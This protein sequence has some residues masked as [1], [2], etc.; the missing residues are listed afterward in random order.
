MAFS[1]RRRL[2]VNL[3]FVLAKMNVVC[4]FVFAHEIFEFLGASRPTRS[5]PKI[6]SC[7]RVEL[8]RRAQKL[9]L[10]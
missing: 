9:E 7:I 5:L 8:K 2:L 1:R 3:H 4:K 6:I 10:L